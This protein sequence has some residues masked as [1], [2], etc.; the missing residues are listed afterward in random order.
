LT[1]EDWGVPPGA[2]VL[3]LSAPNYWI[4]NWTAP[5]TYTR[6]LRVVDSGGVSVHGATDLDSV[7]AADAAQTWVQKGNATKQSVIS[8]RQVSTTV[9]KFEFEISASISPADISIDSVEILIGCT[10]PD[11]V[12]FPAAVSHMPMKARS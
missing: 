6:K 12:S 3:T 8:T 5:V 7:A 11:S 1:W 9:V 2:T 4:I 10:I